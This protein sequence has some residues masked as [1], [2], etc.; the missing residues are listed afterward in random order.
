MDS[1]PQVIIHIDG[2]TKHYGKTQALNDLHLD[3]YRGEVFGYLGPNGAGKTTTIR[4]LLDFIRPTAGHAQIFGLD[5]NRD[6]VKLREHISNLPGELGL[7]KHLNGWDMVDYLG[8][9]RGG[10][11]KA[12]VGELAE[13]LDM[14]M[15]RK[16]GDCSTGMKRK[17]GLI[18]ALMHKPDLLI[19]DEPTNGLDPLVQTTF[20]QL[21]R[22]ISDEGR[23]VFLS[24]HNLREVETICDRVGILR[25]GRL[26]AVERISDL[27]QVRFR[28]MTLVMREPADPAVFEALEGVSDVSAYNGKLHFRV[29][30]ELDQVIKLA[31]QYHVIDLQ[32]EEPSLEEIFLEYYGEKEKNR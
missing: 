27:K 7:W 6:S 11:D 29:T 22:E 14:D 3:V 4:T 8:G 23:T 24:S 15:T 30:G 31:A 5:V 9:L 28:W 1:T 21:M 13:R 16:A 25:D 32:Y 20:H 2:L 26:K 18:Q 12:Y 17:L 19:L 10:V